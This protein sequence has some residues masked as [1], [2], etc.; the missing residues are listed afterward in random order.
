MKRWLPLA[1]AAVSTLA[2]AMGSAGPA[3]AAAGRAGSAGPAGQQFVTRSG[4]AFEIGGKDFR[5]AGT[6]TY[7]LFYKSQTMVDADL[8]KAAAS[9][10]PV[11]RTW[12]WSDTGAAD[13]SGAV[14]SQPDGVYFQYWDGTAPAYNDGANGLAHL[15]YEVWKAKQDGLRLV[16]PFTN[17]WSDFGGMD[18]YVRWAGLTHHDDFYTS[19]LIRGWY[20]AYISH[21]LNHVNPLTGL[22]LKDD[23]TI[24][25]WELANEPRCVGSG[26]YPASASCT[27]S[28]LTSWASD[29]AKYVKGVD[30]H[31]LLGVGDEG[32]WD[33]QP[34]SADSTVNG[35]S[36]DDTLALTAIP[37]IDY[38]SYHLYPDS[39]GK[40]S[41]WGAQWIAAHNIAA[42][43]LGKPAVLGEFGSADKTTRNTVYQQWADAFTLTGGAGLESWMLADKQDDGTLYPDYDGY[44]VYCPSP[45][46][47]ALTNAGVRLAT[48]QLYFPPVADNDAATTPFNTAVTLTPAADD[49]AYLGKVKVSTLDLDPATPGQQT[50]VTIAAGTFALN[51][52]GSV[53]FTPAAG[54]HGKAMISYTVRDGFGTVS[55]TATITVTVK[56]DPTA[57]IVLASFE[58]PDLDGWAPANWQTDAGTM[59]QES[60]FATDGSSGAHVDTV[61][62]GWFGTNLATPV[63]VSGKSTLKVDL[64]TGASAGTSVDIA[65]QNGSSY[66]WCQGNFAWVPAGTTTTFTA[67]LA[68]GFS[69]DGSTLTDIRAIWV[70]L[71]P[72]VSVDMD[73]VRAE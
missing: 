33:T 69:C 41:A 44:T 1:C 50:T 37:Q 29:V 51:A 5:Y 73:D 39:W 66:T 13:G 4:S 28:T 40:D 38:M 26:L 71:S 12:G 20:E 54:F 24:M 72:N 46:C 6:N 52:D 55:N 68:N 57:A 10:F 45:I 59:S 18:Q 15:D 23:P 63:D 61:G 62:G 53:T 21:L 48:G 31:H 19:P 16:I 58:T 32:F 14:A 25:A 70:Y 9:G 3:G 67:D 60:G 8:D 2:F 35:S 64:R 47:Q 43:V 65:V 17:N 22:A 11:V 7:Y 27:T 56:P 49:I 30:H 42:R 34:S 36:G